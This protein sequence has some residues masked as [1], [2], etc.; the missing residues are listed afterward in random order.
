MFCIHC[1]A[2]LP[3]NASFCLNCGKETVKTKEKEE[4]L[5]PV[6]EVV[7]ENAEEPVFEE[8]AEETVAETAE[9]FAVASV[10]EKKKNKALPVI[11][12]AA[13]LLL[14]GFL[15]FVLSIN[16]R[17][18]KVLKELARPD[19]LRMEYAAI[20]I[21][22]AKIC[23]QQILGLIM[24]GIVALVRKNHLHKIKMKD[25]IPF[26]LFVF[27]P[28]LISWMSNLYTV[29]IG[30][31]Y[32]SY[33]LAAIS[34]ATAIL[35]F[36]SLGQLLSWIGLSVFVLA[37]TGVKVVPVVVWA[38]VSAVSFAASVLV[39]VF[40]PQLI[41]ILGAGHEVLDIGSLYLR[42]NAAYAF[43]PVCVSLFFWWS[44]GSEKM[45]F[46]PACIYGPL[47]AVLSATLGSLGSYL[48][49]YVFHLGIVYT[50]IG[51]PVAAVLCGTYI[52]IFTIIG[53]IASKS[54]N[55]KQAA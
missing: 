40:A 9:E 45:W 18:L 42:V 52:L 17:S 53:L 6:E 29:A 16:F 4:N 35:S 14:T 22:F 50:G 13:A 34:S 21:N 15:S 2:E 48:T 20:G 24:F 31:G 54:K 25:L 39:V 37:R 41:R 5:C 49:A 44:W 26:C 8:V 7:P 38:A 33:A 51:T 47:E 3:D 46:V 11:L 12:M 10:P 23:G 32:G 19:A 28:F 30:M 55:K 36:I 1:G 43:I 27:C